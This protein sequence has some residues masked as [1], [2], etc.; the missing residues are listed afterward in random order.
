MRKYR[1]YFYLL[2]LMVCFKGEIISEVSEQTIPSDQYYSHSHNLSEIANTPGELIVRLRSDA[3]FAQLLAFSRK[4]GAKSVSSVFSPTTL[5]G[6]N[7]SLSHIYLIQFPVNSSLEKLRQKYSEHALIEAVEMNRLNR[8]WAETTPNDQ[9]YSE[10]W[11]LK[12]M[13]LPKAWSIEQGKRSVIVAVVDSGIER[14]HPD[15][16]NQL[17]QNPG[18]I[19]SNGIDDD[20]NGYVDDIIGWDFTDAPAFPGHGDWTERDNE[21]EDET[22]HGTQVSGIIAAEANNG[23]GIAGI[24]WGCRL[25][26]LRAGFRIGGGSFLQNDDVAAAIVYAADNGADVI[27]LSLGDTVNAFVIQDAVEYAYSRGCILVAA[28]GNSAEQGSYY[29]AALKNVISVAS[30]DRE[31]QLGG[32]NFGASIDIAAPGEDILTTDINDGQPSI[33]QGYDYKSGTSMA[34]AHV[35][36][37]AAL[38]ISANPSC[39]NVQVKQWLTDTARQFSTT[40]LVGAGI[41]DAYAALTEQSG[42]VAHIAVTPTPQVEISEKSSIIEIFGSAG[43]S[44]FV[45]YWLEYGITETPNLW[46][47]IGFPQTEPKYNTV[48]H[49]WDTSALEEGTYTL[50]LSVKGENG[51]TIRRKTVVEIRHTFPRIS[52]HEASVWFSGNRLDSTIIWHT[53]V[54]TTGVV[55][56]YPIKEN[57]ALISN[58][59]PLRVAHADSVNRQHIVYMSELGLSAGEYLYRLRTQNRSGLIRI[60]DNE[61]RLYPI[62]VTDRHIQP[63]HLRQAASALLGLHAI[64]APKDINGNGKLELIAVETGTTS[65]HVFETDNN[66]NL[67]MI[68]SLDQPDQTMSRV[69]AT[70]DTDGDGLIE[71]LAD[72]SG[73]TFLLEQPAP[74]EFP[75][76]RIWHADGVWGGTIADMD[77][78]GKPEI[79]SR[80]DA[81]DSI[82]VYESDGN[83]SFNNIA[84]LEN[85]TQGKNNLP[86]RFAIGDFDSD[87]QIEILTGD[88]EGE[89]FIYENVG[90]DQYEQTWIGKL[91]DG[92]PHLFAAGD[93]DGDGSAEFAIGA[94]AWTIGIDLPRQHWLFTI[95]SSTGNDSYRAVWHQRIRELQDGE[96]GLTIA[97]A[98]ND[99]R[100][101]L[102]IA[103]SPNFYLVQYDGS[104]Y[105]PIWHHA[106]SSTFNPIVADID[107]DGVNELMFNNGNVFSSFKNPYAIGTPKR[108]TP[109]WGITAKP[110]DETSI[111]LQWQAEQDAVAYTI[112]RGRTQESLVPIRM[113]VK[114]R[115]FS[116]VGLTIGQTY[117]YAVVSHG[118]SGES[119]NKSESVSV[120]PTHPPQLISA[121]HSPPNQLLLAFD[122]PMRPSTANPSR[123][124]LHRV[125]KQ[126]GSGTELDSKD[127]Y[128]PQSAIFDRS[129][130]RVMLTFT[131]DV[132]NGDYD[133]EIE[134][135]QLSD[136]YGAEIP[137]DKR[138]LPVDLSTQSPTEMIVYPNPA[139][140]NQIT[141][142]RLPADSR[143]SIYDV[144][145]NHIASLVPTANETV[146]DRCRKIWNL[147][148]ISSGIYIYVLETDIGKQIGK[149]S[150]IR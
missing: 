126:N 7:P 54:L 127:I 140:G 10:Q 56:I 46:Y 45:Q 122:K 37:V 40:N 124:Q 143:I 133:Y 3:T 59:S 94:K 141:F 79:F 89:L 148:G 5:S 109:P 73:Y 75:T 17:W 55:D 149:L 12:A 53:D 142:D 33:E 43:G 147:A 98:N 120:V 137:E 139:R 26:P 58:N 72:N 81:T 44:G 78:D 2:I 115:R 144:G 23:I 136:I 145:G 113:G 36:G 121:V 135:F 9:R 102:C 107:N 112:H 119:S 150:I 25:M 27:N 111:S 49:E 95:F 106:V 110:V 90:N 42:L 52:N 8:F 16:R 114:E 117:W 93:M 6:Q 14:D 96:S 39:S 34:A 123:Y 68:S 63:S 70:A 64:V 101:E 15:L 134:T 77:L 1:I 138:T 76:N 18:E 60:D 129:R 28:A 104:A 83:N 22:G 66:G 31:N 103:V 128:V 80:H 50:R 13:N 92:I 32:S 69:W 116:D 87:G 125:K 62:T 130:K 97:D 67:V 51:K 91:S 118:L 48:L 4:S 71:V 65:A 41:V 11:N 20:G 88:H 82:S 47:P 38:L 99:G 19:A 131:S 24:A 35:S 105:R 30:T 21:P 29:P 74:D 86:T 85:P 108:L 146:G 132:F 100:N 84:T 57:Q 61:G